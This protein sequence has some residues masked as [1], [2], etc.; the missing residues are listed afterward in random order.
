MERIQALRRLSSDHHTGLVLAR[1]LRGMD[2]ASEIDRER[3]WVDLK[4]RFA[5]E[6]DP[7]FRLEE[8]GVLPALQAV[9][10][11]A[12]VERTLAEHRAMRDRIEQGGPADLETFATLLSDHIRF[13]ETELFA[14]AQRVLDAA[15]LDRLQALHDGAAPPACRAA[16]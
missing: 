14:T 2:A 13:E 16:P 7:H 15:T 1:R 10:E 6:L 8:V 3:T 4:Q 5:E 12:L 11:G 9:G